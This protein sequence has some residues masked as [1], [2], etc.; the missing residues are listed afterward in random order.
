M[1]TPVKL[2]D[3]GTHLYGFGWFLEPWHGHA[4]IGHSGSTSGFSASLQRFP[5]AGLTVILLTNSDEFD[6]ATKLAR[7][8]AELEMGTS[9]SK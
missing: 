5:E 9:S 4:N 2:N 7:E 8:I 3:G 1:W 6:I